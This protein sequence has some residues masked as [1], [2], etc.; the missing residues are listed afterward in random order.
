[1]HLAWCSK[2]VQS[3][4]NA[5]GEL[6]LSHETVVRQG[7][8]ARFLDYAGAGLKALPDGFFLR[9]VRDATALFHKTAHYAGFAGVLCAFWKHHFVR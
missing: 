3:G 9:F 5:M 4:A 2:C 7:N 6:P 8:W 1:M